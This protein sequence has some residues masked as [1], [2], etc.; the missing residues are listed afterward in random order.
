ME[1]VHPEHREVHDYLLHWGRWLRVSNP[2]GQCRSIEHRYRSPQC[3][4]PPEP[5]PEPPEEQKAQ[6]I[7]KVMRIVQKGPRRLLKF[8]YVYRA[9]REW[10]S[11]RLR[12]DGDR[13]ETQL[14][15]ARQIIKVLTFPKLVPTLIVSTH[16]SAR[17]AQT[18][19]RPNGGSFTLQSQS[20]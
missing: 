6:S 13:Y 18:E 5:R 15:T 17:P 10:I 8:K 19:I 9:D 14:Y 7:E 4:Y 12:L 20:T 2:Q 11:K 1:W 16:N 3:W